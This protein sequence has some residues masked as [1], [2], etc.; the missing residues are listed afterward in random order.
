MV[1]QLAPTEV[2]RR[3]KESPKGIVLL[4]VRE[5]W[6]REL[7]HIDPSVH[8]PM[9]DVPTRL[10]ELPKGRPV[11]VYC[12][13]GSRSDMVAGYL[14]GEGFQVSNLKG[15]IDAWSLTVDRKVQRY[16]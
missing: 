12:H 9:N 4:D 13:H 3:L 1:D 2:A 8:I 16:G 15:G 7:A 14:E 10:A 6:E 11:V 5:D